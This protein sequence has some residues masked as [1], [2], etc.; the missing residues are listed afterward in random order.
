MGFYS[1]PRMTR[2]SDIIVALSDRDIAKF[3]KLFG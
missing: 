3:V 2:D 1:I